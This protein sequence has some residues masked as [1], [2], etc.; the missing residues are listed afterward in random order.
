MQG[1]N[2]AQ[3]SKLCISSVVSGNSPAILSLPDIEMLAIFSMGCNTIDPQ[4][5]P[6]DQHTINRKVPM[7]TSS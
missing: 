1:N 4:K 6:R 2:Y 7:Q 5:K 3:R